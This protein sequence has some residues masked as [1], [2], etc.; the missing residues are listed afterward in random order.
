VPFAA[1]LVGGDSATRQPMLHRVDT[2]TEDSVGVRTASIVLNVLA[3]SSVSS[4][5]G[6]I[7]SVLRSDRAF[8]HIAVNAIVTRELP[9]AEERSELM[10]FY[11]TQ[12]A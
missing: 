2:A 10:S 11:R 5:Y 1:G 9:Y 7:D 4:L 6:E 3:G 8:L 12:S